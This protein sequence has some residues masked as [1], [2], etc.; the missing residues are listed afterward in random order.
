MRLS[1]KVT[2]NPFQSYIWIFFKWNLKIEIITYF[3][4][5]HWHLESLISYTETN[6]FCVC[7]FFESHET[8]IS[9]LLKKDLQGLLM[10]YACGPATLWALWPSLIN[11]PGGHHT[12]VRQENS[13]DADTWAE[14]PAETVFRAWNMKPFGMVRKVRRDCGVK[15]TEKRKNH[16][17]LSVLFCLL[18]SAGGQTS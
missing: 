12:L 11:G 17:T 4:E 13:N 14:H 9:P 1:C 6:Y 10:Q 15:K 8:P 3:S 5:Q 7:V 2:F 18:F 16:F